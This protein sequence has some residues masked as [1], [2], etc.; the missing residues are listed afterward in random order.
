[1]FDSLRARLAL[2][3]ALL[4]IVL[5]PVRADAQT[6]SE[7]V[8]AH[9]AVIAGMMVAIWEP[10]APGKVPLVLFS[11]GFG[12]CGTQST[13]L[14]Q[15]LAARGYVVMAP[16]H[17]DS[18]CIGQGGPGRPEI[19]FHDAPKWSDATYRDRGQD[20]VRLIAALKAD[21]AWRDRI[22]FDH[23][24]L[25]GHSLGGYTVLGLAGAWPSWRQAGIGAVLALSPYAR[26]FI[27]KGALGSMKV[28]VMYQGGTRDLGI[29]PF[30]KMRGGAFDKTS[31]PVVFVE[32][33]GAAHLAWTDGGRPYHAA[34]LDYAGP[35]L[36]R[37]LKGRGDSLPPKGPGIAE[38]RSK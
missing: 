16:E 15:G 34:I 21:P 32:L 33:E 9:A 20:L 27:I 17:Q 11:H 28:P 6:Q 35:F 7:G 18:S 31:S 10:R 38:I 13:F 3:I 4:P 1:M 24:G 19:P 12:S 36:D 2:L 26:P 5:A 30:V 8:R 37:W 23:V 29:T 22:D 14:T 25:A